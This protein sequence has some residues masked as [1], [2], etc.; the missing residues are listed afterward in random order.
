MLLS[1]HQLPEVQDLCDRV[2]IVNSGRVV[3]EGA[4][5]DLRR[6]GGAGYRCARPM[7][8][9]PWS[10]PRPRRGRAARAPRRT[11]SPSRP[12]SATLARSRSRLP[13]PV[14]AILALTPGDGRRSR[15]CSSGSPRS[16]RGARRQPAPRSA[17]VRRR[18]SSAARPAAAADAARERAA[19][20]DAGRLPL[21]AAQGSCPCAHLSGHRARCHP[22]A[23]LRRLPE[24]PSPPRP[25]REHLCL[26]DH[27][28]RAGDAGA[29]AVVPVRL[30]AARRH[31]P[32]RGRHRRQRGRQRHAED[33]PH[34]LGRSRPGVRRQG[35][36][37]VH[38]RRDRR[39]RLGH[40]GHGRRHRLVGL[41]FR[42]PRSRAPSY[43]PPKRCCSWSPPTPPT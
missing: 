17:R 21:G 42:A 18:V 39:L 41:S 27:P 35:A 16:L 9:A 13:A 20:L 3:Y 15:I 10:S 30:H 33:D 32:R 40:R 24:R 4:L 11:A 19:P 8:R 25:R 34:A 31:R 12:R 29:D 5:A 2:A 23:V 37:R 36:R 22:A 38:L 6:Q 7:T 43:R 26:A 28:V 1:S 14:S